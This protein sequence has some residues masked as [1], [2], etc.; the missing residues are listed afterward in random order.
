MTDNL[1]TGA[2]LVTPRGWYEH[3][4]IYAGNGRVVHY[5]GYCHGL[6]TGPVEEVSLEQFCGGQGF[7]I[8][9]QAGSNYT[10]A[11]IVERARSRIGEQR[12]HLL[13]NNCEHFCEWAVNGRSCSSQVE[14]FLAFPQALL[15]RVLDTRAL[16]WVATL[17]TH[18][19]ATY[20]DAAPLTCVH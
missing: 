18:P 12:Y 3:H 15:R 10:P 1:P 11:E 14:R 5:A 13:A 9:V 17:V 16:R 4:G 6:H 7:A 8:R 2:H 19:A 20:A